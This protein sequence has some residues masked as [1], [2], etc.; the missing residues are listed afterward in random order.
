M[1][2]FLAAP[3][4]NAAPPAPFREKVLPM[5][6]ADGDPDD[7]GRVFSVPV[8]CNEFGAEFELG[9]YGTTRVSSS[10]ARRCNLSVEKDR[11]LE[12]MHDP[13]DKPMFDGS[14]MATISVGGQ[15]RMVRVSVMKDQYCQ[16]P[17]KEG[18]LGFDVLKDFQWEIDPAALTFTLRPATTVPAKKPLY[19]LPMRVGEDGYYLKVRIRN[20]TQ[21]LALM[22]GSSFIQA[23]LNLQRAWDLTSGDKIKVDVNRFGDVRT[24]WL[25]GSDVV[26]LT[27]YLKETDLPVALMGDAKKPQFSGMLDSGLGQCVLN[28]YVYCVEPR[29]QQFRI[30]ART[31]P[32]TQ[33]AGAS[34]K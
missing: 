30:M 34:A 19:I 12:R 4:L 2:G 9:C 7:P 15:E 20:V 1:A 18:L 32:T 3:R 13:D 21:D 25:R 10:L 28:R 29:R 27:R 33:A 17:E 22:P 24:T 31:A 11:V 23:G 26:E 14:A 8:T 6:I 16:K 5:K